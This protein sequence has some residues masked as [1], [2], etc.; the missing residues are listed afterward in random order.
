MGERGKVITRLDVSTRRQRVAVRTLRDV[1]K[2]M[3][4]RLRQARPQWRQ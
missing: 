3:L 1:V 4:A 2:P